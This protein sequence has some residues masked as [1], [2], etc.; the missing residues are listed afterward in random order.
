MPLEY[1]VL[2]ISILKGNQDDIVSQLNYY[3][4]D[5]WSVSSTVPEFDIVILQ[6]EL[7]INP[8]LRELQ[9]K[10]GLENGSSE[11]TENIPGEGL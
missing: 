7:E 1:K 10:G 4:A 6:R 3:G 2:N 11:T 8:K 5:N 9:L